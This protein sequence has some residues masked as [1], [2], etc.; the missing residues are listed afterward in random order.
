MRK[1]VLLMAA[2]VTLSGCMYPIRSEHRS[3]ADRSVTIPML[4]ENPLAHLGKKVIVGGV[5]T[6]NRED[7]GMS[8]LVI[9]SLPLD[10]DL[11]PDRDA[12]PGDRFYARSAD[13]LTPMEFGTGRF[14]TLFGEVIGQKGDA[15]PGRSIPVISIREIHP[16]DPD[17][18]SPNPRRDLRNENPY[19]DTYLTPMKPRPTDA[20]TDPA[21]LR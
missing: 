11:V 6:E 1:I 7:Q 5:V 8:L 18:F 10:D 2:L 16:W 4:L 13:I 14:V 20:V 19:A 9:A 21:N 15:E 12:L 3:A 17:K